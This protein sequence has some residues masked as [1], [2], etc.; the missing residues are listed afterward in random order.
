MVSCRTDFFYVIIA[1]CCLVVFGACAPANKQGAFPHD[2][3]TASKVSSHSSPQ[4]KDLDTSEPDA[5]APETQETA[6]STAGGQ[7]GEDGEPSGENAALETLFDFPVT[8]NSQVEY[9]LELFQTRYR[10]DFSRWLSRS[11]RYLPLIQEHLKEV[12]LPLDLAYLAM[13]E[14]GFSERAFSSAKAVGL[15]QFVKPTAKDFDLDVNKYVD[16]RRDPIKST[17]AAAAYLSALYQEFGSWYLAVAAYNAGQ[18]KIRRA[19]AMYDTMDFWELTE[20]SYLQPETKNYVPQLIAAMLIAKQPEKYGFT[21]IV[22]EEPLA[23]DTVPVPKGT[24]VK[25]VSLACGLDEDVLLAYNR[26]LSKSITPPDDPNYAIRVPVGKKD[27]VLNNLSRVRTS[28][29][30]TFKTHVVR[31][32]ES[33]DAV[34]KNYGITK[35]R[36]LKANDLRS[37]KLK[38]GQRL[39]IP[40]QTASYELM[41]EKSEAVGS[42]AAN[43]D[44]GEGAGRETAKVAAKVEKSGAGSSAKTE[45]LASN[46]KKPTANRDSDEELYYRVQEGDSLW[47]IAQKH[48]LSPASIRKWNNLRDDTIQPGSRLILKRTKDVSG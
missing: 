13:I 31:K 39:Q 15:W 29:S 43:H 32:G 19:I 25:A 30:T 3:R 2:R 7:E 35:T 21:D 22:Y 20:G 44:K 45:R 40:Y 38:G 46:I 18:G 23:F 17:M 42:V 4:Q 26:E 41:S 48:N 37:T 6:E 5:A 1:V 14:S 8:I 11:G 9:H 47:A 27:E 24:A 28:V 10:N 12:G 36:L 33:I 16:E 34:C